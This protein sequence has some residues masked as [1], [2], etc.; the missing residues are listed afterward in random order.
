MKQHKYRAVRTVVDGISFPSKKEAARYVV[1][2]RQELMGFISNLR[3]QV[4]YELNEGG[5]FKYAYFA[6]F[7]YEQAGITY[8]EDSKGYRTREYK[9]KAKLMLKIYGITIKEV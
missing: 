9:K 6:D 1:L 2:K 5:N 8:V 3:R 7:V 4:R